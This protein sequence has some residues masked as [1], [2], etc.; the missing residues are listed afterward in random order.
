MV[1]VWRFIVYD[2]INN[3]VN[4][5]VCVVCKI[6]NIRKEHDLKITLQIFEKIKD[7]LV[8]YLKNIMMLINHIIKL[9]NGNFYISKIWVVIA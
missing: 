7:V 3:K 1:E 9:K 2:R 4:L 6:K 8:L 5:K